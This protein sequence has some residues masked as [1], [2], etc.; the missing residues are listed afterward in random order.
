MGAIFGASKALFDAH[1]LA[2]KKRRTRFEWGEHITACAG[3]Q[4]TVGRQKVGVV[5]D[6]RFGMLVAGQ[7]RVVQGGGAQAAR[8]WRDHRALLP[9][10]VKL[11]PFF[12]AA[13]HLVQDVQYQGGLSRGVAGQAAAGGGREKGLEVTLASQVTLGIGDQQTASC[14]EFAAHGPVT[15][16]FDQNLVAP[17]AQL[18]V[19]GFVDGQQLA[20]H[21]QRYL[22]A[23]NVD[24]A[25]KRGA[26]KTR[27]FVH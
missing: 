8:V 9:H 1:A 14:P 7:K 16:Q 5:D 18:R 21:Q 10:A 4:Q 11:F 17:K 23:I 20:I 6:Q 25:L 22:V 24:R 26:L 27:C 15:A 13:G 2:V 3:E 19:V 12:K